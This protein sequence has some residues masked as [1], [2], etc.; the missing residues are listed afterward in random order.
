MG[1]VVDGVFS[2][3]LLIE[4]DVHNHESFAR[5]IGIPP[6]LLPVFKG[7][8]FVRPVCSDAVGSVGTVQ[9]GQFHLCGCIDVGQIEP[10][11]RVSLK[12]RVGAGSAAIVQ[13]RPSFHEVPLA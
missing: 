2:P 8:K 9:L 4:V 3:C 6:L 5:M 1:S 10:S 13:I 11:Y 7:E 12:G